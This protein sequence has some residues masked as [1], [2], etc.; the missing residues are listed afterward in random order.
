MSAGSNVHKSAQLT[1]M[2]LQ[3]GVV[4]PT[5]LW[6]GEGFASSP[7]AAGAGAQTRLWLQ[8][9]SF[10]SSVGTE[11]GLQVCP[12][13]WGGQLDLL[14]RNWLGQVSPWAQGQEGWGTLRSGW[15]CEKSLPFSVPYHPSVVQA[16]SPPTC[17]MAPAY[18]SPTHVLSCPHSL[19]PLSSQKPPE[20]AHLKASKDFLSHFR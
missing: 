7:M 19:A 11:M 20:D 12:K 8:S 14:D 1:R 17:T 16:T 6:E 18:S 4:V 9:R 2:V 13:P 15:G 10:R 5:K 3:R